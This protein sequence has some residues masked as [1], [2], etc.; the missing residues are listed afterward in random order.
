M[1]Q[2]AISDDTRTCAKCGQAKPLD[3]FK[4]RMQS[5]NGKPW[6]QTRC[7][8]CLRDDVRIRHRV[9]AGLPTEG[10]VQ[11]GKPRRDY[12]QPRTCTG[13]CGR[14]LP[15]SEFAVHVGN[16]IPRQLARCRDCRLDAQRAR[17]ATHRGICQQCG[18]ETSNPAY[19]RCVG[20]S[21][22]APKMRVAKP[23]PARMAKPKPVNPPKPARELHPCV[24]CGVG[25]TSNLTEC[26]PCRKKRQAAG[27]V[28]SDAKVRDRVRQNT[29]KRFSAGKCAGLLWLRDG[30]VWTL[31]YVCQDCTQPLLAPGK[32]W[33]CATGKPRQLRRADGSQIPLPRIEA[34]DAQQI[35]DE[36]AA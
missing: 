14:T 10:P 29:L 4:V 32:C 22:H 30:D 33:S 6:R 25:L 28:S 19:V 16:G 5:S 26:T 11:R 21:K 24:G 27:H 13:P 3:E 34:R 20:C 7:R 1:T 23:K 12:S 18:A 17:T 31:E 9:K 15:G 35:D 2:L 8:S 36:V